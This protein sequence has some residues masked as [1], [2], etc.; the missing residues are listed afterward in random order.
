MPTEIGTHDKFQVFDAGRI[1]S[2]KFGLPWIPACA[3][4]TFFYRRHSS[5][6]PA[7]DVS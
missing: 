7:A 3:G 6:A 1:E 5:R 2:S 4:M